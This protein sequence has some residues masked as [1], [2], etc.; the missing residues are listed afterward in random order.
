MQIIDNPNNAFRFM[1]SQAL[2]ENRWLVQF[3]STDGTQYRVG[4]RAEPSAF[5]VYE[6]TPNAN[7]NTV[8]QYII[9]D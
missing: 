2:S 6:S 8:M 4:V 9:E 1:G 5:T 3:N 7:P